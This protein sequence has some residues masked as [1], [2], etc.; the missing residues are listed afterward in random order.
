MKELYY[1]IIVLFMSLIFLKYDVK[2]IS[3]YF[4]KCIYKISFRKYFFIGNNVII[5][6]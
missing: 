4:N 2:E 5:K 6:N 3:N 1:N